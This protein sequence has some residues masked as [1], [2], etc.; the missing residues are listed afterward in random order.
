MFAVTKKNMVHPI[1]VIELLWRSCCGSESEK[2]EG[3]LT[4]RLKVRQRTQLL[5]DHSLL[6][7]SSAEGVYLHDIVLQYL[8]KRLSVEGLRAAQRQVVDGMVAASRARIAA[9]G[10]GF[11][12]T[13]STARAYDGEEVSK[14]ETFVHF[15]VR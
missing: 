12:D 11:Q 8:H 6:L 2:Q 14:L 5:V 7:G 3:S 10:R 1:A 4:T 15:G 13:G 9:T